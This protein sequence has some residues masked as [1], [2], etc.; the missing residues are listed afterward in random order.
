MKARIRDVDKNIEE[1][2]FYFSVAL[3]ALLLCHSDKLSATLQEEEFSA[4]GVQNIFRMT[5]TALISFRS[6][7]SFSLFWDKVLMLS[8]SAWMNLPFH[9]KKGLIKVWEQ[10]W[11]SLLSDQCQRTLQKIYFEAIDVLTACLQDR[12]DQSDFN[13]Y[14]KLEQVLPKSAKSECFEEEIEECWR[15]YGSELDDNTLKT[16]LQIFSGICKTNQLDT[17][18]LLSDIINLF[19]TL[20]KPQIS[21]ISQVA[22]LLKLILVMPA[23]NAVSERF[24]SAMRRL[25]T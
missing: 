6:N 21:L 15:F 20:T 12:F 16:Q 19:K 24:F 13:M 10:Q 11:W 3:G 17:G 23:T 5:L 1:F 25:K 18:C 14:G 4:A 2:D 22:R 7:D 8:K 9:A